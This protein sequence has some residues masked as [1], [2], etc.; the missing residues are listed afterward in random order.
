MDKIWRLYDWLHILVIIFA[1]WSL[2]LSIRYI[3][4]FSVMFISIKKRYQRARKDKQAEYQERMERI[5]LK[6]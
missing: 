3:Y 5:E 2:M 4:K 1:I 6:N